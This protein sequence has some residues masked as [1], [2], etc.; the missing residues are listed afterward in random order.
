[1]GIYIAIYNVTEAIF[2]CVSNLVPREREPW[3][4]GWYVSWLPLASVVIIVTYH[5]LEI[6]LTLR[7][8][9]AF[10]VL[11]SGKE[12]GCWLIACI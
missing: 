9:E 7:S 12:K 8:E 1:M 10:L 3:E 11:G 6:F 4:R 2:S 5:K